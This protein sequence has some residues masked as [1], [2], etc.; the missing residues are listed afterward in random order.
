MLGRSPCQANKPA[1]HART[2]E[3]PSKAGHSSMLG[4]PRGEAMKPGWIA[5]NMRRRRV[6]GRPSVLERASFHAWQ[7]TLPSDEA[8]EGSVEHASSTRGRSAFHAWKSVPETRHAVG[9]RLEGSVSIPWKV[10]GHRPDGPWAS[11]G[12]RGRVPPNVHERVRGSAQGPP[13]LGLVPIL[14]PPSMLRTRSSIVKPRRDRA[15]RYG[16]GL[17]LRPAPR[18]CCR[19]PARRSTRA[20]G[21]HG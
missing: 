9:H 4:R 21:S 12:G 16:S 8:R 13:G 6:E 1:F 10:A 11:P 7:V 3:L 5:W 19:H 20:A 15:R 18:R 14:G 17:P 2:S